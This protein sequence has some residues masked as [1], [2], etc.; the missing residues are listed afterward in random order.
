MSRRLLV[1]R[2]EPAASATVARARRRGLDAFAVPLFQ[3][4][5]VAWDAPDASRFDALLLTSANAVRHGGPELDKLRL[6]PVHAVGDATA[7][8]ARSAGFA[9]A[10]TGEAGVDALL[11][12]IPADLALLHLCGEDRREPANAR[13]QITA[14]PVYRAMETPA[15]HLRA[16][17]CVALIHS[18]RAGRRFA[19]LMTNR[20]SIAIAAIS[21]AAADAVGSGWESVAVAPTPTDDALLA[22][23]ERLCNNRGA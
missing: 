9:V 12:A 23:A 13:Q 16:E 5:P 18:P 2:P 21:R 19:E 4:E 7:D 6:L 8:A 1:L 3:I 17:G 15:P 11:D 20:G 22:L 10:S 14:V